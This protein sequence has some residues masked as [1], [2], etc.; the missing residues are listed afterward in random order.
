MD[1]SQ[2]FTSSKEL[3]AFLYG[4][5]LLI[6][7][8]SDFSPI[9]QE[10]V[11]HGYITYEKGIV[12]QKARYSCRRCG[13]E[14]Q[15]H[16][17]S[18]ICARCGK[19]CAY[20][21]NCIIMGKVRSCES[22]ISWTGPPYS[23]SK[24]ENALE[25]S[26]TLSPAQQE[27]S[28]IVVEAVKNKKVCLVWAV[29]GAGKTEVLFEGIAAALARGE[30][31]CISTPRTDVVLELAP[32]LKAAFPHVPVA[33][34]YGGSEEKSICAQ[35]VI[36]TTHQLLRY[37]NAFDL[38]VVDEV[39]AFPYSADQALQ[40]AVAQSRK[41]SSALVYLTATPSRSLRKRAATNE[42]LSVTIPARFHRH[43]IPVPEYRWCGNW[44]KSF[45]KKKIPKQVHAWYSQQLSNQT[46]FLLFFPTIRLMNEYLP[47]FQ[48][49]YPE[50]L[51]VHSEDED[52]KE[53]VQSLREGKVLG[54]LTTT[55]LERGVTIPRL[56]VAVIGAEEAIFTESALV[57][58]AGR[59]GRKKDAPD[60][61]IIF[62]H[63][64]KTWA[65]KR[66]VAQINSMNEAA[67][68]RGLIDV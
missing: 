5:S 1:V 50:L 37:K 36:S 66:A 62:F 35:L 58:I 7:E 17:Y 56:N 59:V 15:R 67:L 13:T 63:Y 41:P 45:S 68:E 44:K 64:G 29:C 27:A 23:F 34:L 65:M 55:I 6:D 28:S 19:I 43:S 53:K 4:K 38:V 31:V 2:S 24:L 22:L 9:L 54:L 32:R 16:F 61:D 3:Q 52:R 21:R 12:E 30:R 60:G 48:Q 33:A 57:Q 47:L 11:E 20:C 40:Y 49:E 14:D 46:P 25:W 26:G 42:I 39:D 8:L 18:H 10:H 51:S